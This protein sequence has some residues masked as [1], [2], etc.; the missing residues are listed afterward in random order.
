MKRTIEILGSGCTRCQE[1]YRIVED[2]IETE[3]FDAD[4]VRSESVARLMHLSVLAT[5]AVA[6]DGEIVFSGRIPDPDD[7][8][9]FLGIPRALVAGS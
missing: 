6:V 3:H 4:L 9:K 2:V 5:P 1:T 8:R 7:V